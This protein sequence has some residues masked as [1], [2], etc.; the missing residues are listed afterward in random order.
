VSLVAGTR[1]GHYEVLAL[2]GAGGM[3]EVYRARDE[4]LKRNVAIK[5]LPAVFTSDPERLR[6]FEQEAQTAGGL[7]H[8]NITSVY[9]L[10]E[11][12]ASLYIVQELLEGE[13][14]RSRLAGGALPVRK[15]TD[16]AIQVARGLA[17]AHEKGIVHR[18]LKPENLFITKDGR[19]KI[20]DFG[21]AKLTQADGAVGPQTNLPTAPP[22]T[23]PGV[24]MGTLGYMSP[25]QVKGKAADARSDI[26]AFGA[27]LYE[28]LS[29]VRAFHRESAAETMSAIMREEPPDLSATNKSVQPGLERVVRHC[30]EKNPEERFHSAHDLAFDLESLSG[31][32]A[33]RPTVDTRTTPLR[34]GRAPLLVGIVLALAGMAVTYW[35]GK[36]AGQVQ[37]AKFHQ[38]TFRRGTIASARFAPDG[39]TILYTAAWDGNP[40]EVFVSRLDSPESRPFG[41]SNAEVLSV[42]PSGEMAVS[43]NRRGSLPFT[44]TGTLA[45]LGMTGGGTP[46]EILEDV[47][48]AEWAPDG[49]SLA[50]V[51][52]QGGKV[53]LEYPIGKVLYET[54]GWISHPRISPKGDEVAFLD[55][56][57]QGDDAGAASIVDRSGKRRTI[58]E[59]FP[60]AQGL[61]WSP[62]GSEVW[63][64]AASEGFNR[65]LR[66]ATRSGRGRILAQATGGLTVQD[67][68]RTGRVLAFQ[69]KAR[70]GISVLLPGSDKERDFSWLD[71][72]L[73]R[74]VTPDGQMI[75]FDETGEGGGPG[76]SVYVRKA[77]GSPA[78][79]LG[80]GVGAELSP[81]GRLA[82][83]AEK[84]GDLSRLVIY[85]IGAGEPKTLP[86]TPIHIEQA[87]W[88]P[89]GRRIIFSGSEPDRGSRI[90]VQ[91][92]DEAKQK[93]VS[94]EGYR[95]FP[96][97]LTPDG[98]HVAAIGPDQRFYQY[99][100]DGG[101][102]TP[103]PGLVK[104]DVP[105]QWTRDG[106]SL[107]VRRRGDIPQRIMKLDV[108]TGRKDLWR[109]LMPPDPAGIWTVS[110]V[111]ITPDEKYYAYGFA[112][113]LADLYVV[114]GLK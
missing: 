32:S 66:A 65:A 104:G 56:P 24:V 73:I 10:G 94:P 111:S 20:L 27:I 90:W 13:T 68:S 57:A 4:K 77:D 54:A 25:E 114:D 58:S 39:Q 84:L 28:M 19:V 30:L 46:K 74:D 22:A 98:R 7:N 106:R 8:P 42:S 78:V 81:D 34:V 41:L 86:P 97:C 26:F 82:L 36:R 15:A 113:S 105:G 70:Q 48:W 50:V 49:Q 31:A 11:H 60:S 88:L 80:R 71:W 45:R 6:R 67:V 21:L 29:G 53:R 63:F 112:R 5:V 100:V 1:L 75:L 35:L 3:G 110:P 33:P 91:G 43:L 95:M 103:I 40:L 61:A 72:G 85:P 107:F 37:P 2:L 16:Y 108:A 64:T 12:E 9:E 93:P 69:E 38:L 52:Q 55:H 109:E 62:D 51:R 96:K 83:G 87:G 47:L 59:I 23:E 79:R 101:E 92:L 89:D 44:R 76:Y 102:P 14:L 99:P 17:A 18:D